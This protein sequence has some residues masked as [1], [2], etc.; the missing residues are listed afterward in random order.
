MNQKVWGPGLWLF[1]HTLTFNYPVN[2][3]KKDKERMR[4]FFMSLGDILPCRYCRENYAKHLKNNPI[5]LNSKREFVRWV[6]C[7]H[8]EVNEQE[9]KQTVKELDVLQSYE[10]IYGKKIELD[11]NMGMAKN[12]LFGNMFGYVNENKNN[13]FTFA[14]FVIILFFIF[15]LY[16]KKKSLKKLSKRKK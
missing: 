14:I 6:I 8:N 13:F 4:R 15:F 7:I 5:K 1:L 12:S 9:G 11:E 10:K 3:K 2:P 16:S